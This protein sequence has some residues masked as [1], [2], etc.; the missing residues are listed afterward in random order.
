MFVRLSILLR[1]RLATHRPSCSGHLSQPFI[2]ACLGALLLVAPS[3]AQAESAAILISAEQLAESLTAAEPDIV[4]L[5]TRE[6]DQFG[7]ARIAGAR[8]VDTNAWRTKTFEPNGLNERVFWSEELGKL[9]IS[10][11]KKIVVIGG[12]LPEA[13]RLWWLLRYFGMNNVLLLDGGHS[14]WQAAGLPIENGASTTADSNPPEGTS[15]ASEIDFQ[16]ELLATIQDLSPESLELSKSKIIDNRSIGEYTG[17]RGIGARTGHIPEAFHL[18]WQK[19]IGEDGKFLPPESIKKILE[20]VQVDLNQ[21]LVT[22]CQSGGRSSVAA[23]ALTLAG[24]K[25]VKNFYG[26]WAEYGNAVTLP[27][28]KAEKEAKEV[29]P[30]K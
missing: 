2:G 11:E 15:S 10:K 17:T 29:E 21:P 28:E 26:G 7:Q 27:V 3:F 25:Q 9:A 12:T 24:A 20:E 16:E 4:L 19:F 23:F 8:W 5:D 14:A 18:E 22:H 1:C 6:Q 13:A 30:E